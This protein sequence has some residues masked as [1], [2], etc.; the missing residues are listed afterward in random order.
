MLREVQ[1]GLERL[2]RVQTDLEVDDF[3]VGSELRASAGVARHPREQLLLSEDE[4]G[5]SVGLFVDDQVLSNVERFDPRRELK[6]R[7]LE[8]FLLVVEGVSHFVYVI[9]RAQREQQVSA[10]ELELQ[11]EVDKYVTCLLHFGDD[12]SRSG[13][14]RRRLF[15]DVE[16]ESDLDPVE[17]DR[18]KVA[19]AN[20]H[21]YSGF[22][23]RTF[24]RA[25]R[26]PA[27]LRELRR[28]YRMALRRKLEHIAA[29]A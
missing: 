12:G 23:E 24:V 2:Y 11:A 17:R 10:L 16:F 9:W 8:D 28:F 26:I 6:D 22:L 18:Y 13:E 7:N 25:G 15:V 19:N 14:L 21:R 5:L 27:M 3:L 1:R 4:D 29:A 20:A